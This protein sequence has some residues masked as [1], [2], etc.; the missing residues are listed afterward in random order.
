[1]NVLVI[2]CGVSGLTTALYLLREGH[3]VTIW[4]KDLPP[5]TTSNMAAAVWYPYQ[6]YPAEKVT[7]WGKSAYTAFTQMIGIEGCGVFM[8]TVMEL[9]SSPHADPWWVSAIPNFRHASPQELRPGYQDAYVFEAPVID[10]HVYLDYLVCSVQ[11]LGGKIERRV[12]ND[13]SEAFVHSAAVINCSGLGA[14]D[15][16][17]DTELRPARGQ[18]VRIRHNGSRLTLLDEDGPN[19]LAY[20][21]PRTHDIILGGTYEENIE[22]IEVD[23]QEARAI[24]RRCAALAPEFAHV[25]QEDILSVQCGLRPVRSIIRLEAERPAPDRLLLHNYGHGGAG[26]TLSWGCAQEVASL[27][28]QHTG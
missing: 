28:H 25:S 23:P 6:A 19:R 17:H 26:I 1:M 14:R 20:I 16:L 9:F 5:Y 13:L 12:L 15:L 27:L 21:V 2:G 24:L 10:T 8:T 4:A 11:T 18:T 3:N 22:S 7:V